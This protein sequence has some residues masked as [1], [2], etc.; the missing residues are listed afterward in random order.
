MA[1]AY[2]PYFTKSIP[3]HIKIQITIHPLSIDGAIVILVLLQW[4]KI[5][6]YETYVCNF[7]QTKQDHKYPIFNSK[8]I[9]TG[10]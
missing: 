8:K 7:L 4:L 6:L 10:N 5:I 3:L 1:K 9:E 2:H